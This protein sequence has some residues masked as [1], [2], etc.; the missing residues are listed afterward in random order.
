MTTCLNNNSTA[1]CKNDTL[2]PLNFSW[3]CLQH[4]NDAPEFVFDSRMVTASLVILGKLQGVRGVSRERTW[5]SAAEVSAGR[6]NTLLPLACDFAFNKWLM[7]CDMLFLFPLDMWQRFWG[8]ELLLDWFNRETKWC[9]SHLLG[10]NLS[11]VDFDP[12]LC[13]V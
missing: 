6:E 13:S 7:C 4:S 5:L 3:T 1:N 8:D 10:A 9:G 11:L 12:A 2:L